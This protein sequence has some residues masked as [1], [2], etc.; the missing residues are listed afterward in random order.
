MERKINP[1]F[2]HMID[3]L[4]IQSEI[5]VDRPKGSIHPRYPTLVYPVDYGHLKNTS[6]MDQE[7]IDIWIGTK[8]EK[9]AEA[10]IVTTD[11]LKRDSEIKILFGCTEEEY[12]LIYHTHNESPYMKGILIRRDSEE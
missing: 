11:I 9:K 10:I 6:S 4:I 5:T 1:A 3:K 2:W 8:A 12:E 7:G